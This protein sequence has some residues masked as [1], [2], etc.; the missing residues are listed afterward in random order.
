[1]EKRP[2][3]VRVKK[4]TV[5]KAAR[6]AKY[7][8]IILYLGIALMLFAR[9]RA[10][11]IKLEKR[12]LT[13]GTQKLEVEIADNNEKRSHGLMF[14]KELKDG[15]GMIFIFENE[16]PLNFWMKNTLI[17]LSIGYFDKDKKLVDI[18]DMQPASPMDV[19]PLT[20]PST[21]P[22][23]YALEVPLGWYAKHKIKPGTKFTLS[24]P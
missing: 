10:A 9:A 20:Y 14:R 2:D 21:R 24:R 19:Q 3:T 7:I 16:Q 13:I 12:S 15:K 17:P 11:D 22:A 8:R 18:L 4:A 1:M 23:K 5:N 6:I